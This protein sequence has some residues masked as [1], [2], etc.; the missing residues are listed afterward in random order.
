MATAGVL[1]WVVMALTTDMMALALVQPL[2][3]LTL[4][5]Y[6]LPACACSR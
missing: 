6:I 2:H 5:R 3:G 1:R 4:R